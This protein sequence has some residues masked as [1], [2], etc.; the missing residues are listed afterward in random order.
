MKI[1]EKIGNAIGKGI[2]KGIEVGT[3]IKEYM[4][5]DTAND[6]KKIFNDKD[7]RNDE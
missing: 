7:K 6:L 1:G 4:V 5:D 2:D 3:K